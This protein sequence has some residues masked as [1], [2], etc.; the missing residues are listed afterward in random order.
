MSHYHFVSTKK[1]EK[2]V[3]QLGEN[4]KNIFFVGALSLDNILRYKYLNKKDLE[5]KLNF[6]FRK[7]NFLLTYHPLTLNTN[8]SK[9][10]INI[11]LKAL[12]KYKDCGII[13]TKSNADTDSKVINSSIDKFVK[14]N[15]HR[16][17]SFNSLGS[18]LYFSVLKH[19][20]CYIEIH[21]VAS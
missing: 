8:N 14:K 7:F 20:Q 1:Y 17:V 12:D 21:Q 9:N 3:N 5:K 19:S 11:I 18:L 10:Q 15:Q 13:F 6:K 4:K 2:R 16:C